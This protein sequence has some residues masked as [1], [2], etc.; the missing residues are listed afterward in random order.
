MMETAFQSAFDTY[1]WKT[2]HETYILYLASAELQR[3]AFLL[4]FYHAAELV[5]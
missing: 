5:W 3:P 1:R 2:P 4:W